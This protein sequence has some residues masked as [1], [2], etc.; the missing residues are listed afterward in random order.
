MPRD[1]FGAY[2]L[3]NGTLVNAGD[4]IQPS[5]HNPAMSDLG[6]N[7]TSSLSRDGLGGM[8]A[9]LDM[10]GFDITNVGSI[11]AA[12]LG[13]SG[14]VSI[15]GTLGVTGAATFTAAVSA[16]TVTAT[17]NAF[18][19]GTH[20]FGANDHANISGNANSIFVRGNQVIIQDAAAAN[21]WGQFDTNGLDL[22]ARNIRWSSLSN[23]VISPNAGTPLV[24]FDSGDLISYDRTSNTMLFLIGS[25]T[26]L[27]LNGTGA[28]DKD[29]LELGWKE[30][31]QN[32]QGSGYT[33]ALTDR[34]KHV[35]YNGA[36]ANIT[37]PTNASVPFPIGTVIILVNNGSGNLTIIES[38][39]VLVLAG[40]GLV[41]NRTL[42]PTG[43]AT[44]LK[45]STDGW[46]VSGAG[47]S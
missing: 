22:F 47:L 17:T 7:I 5:Q 11:S 45:V 26:R 42:I 23:F 32:I 39:T 35:Y 20:F 6:S 21:T 41:G 3:P 14:N 10:G 29:S 31:P 30:V 24:Q 15:G 2:S 43:M 18:T 16:L 44:F 9:D 27:F 37:V 8:R 28:F 4:V 34:A 25:A 46:F 1:S 12:I 13:I 19:K 33:F 38:G 36:A 40:A